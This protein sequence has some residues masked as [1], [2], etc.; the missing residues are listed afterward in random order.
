MKK[1]TL[2]SPPDIKFFKTTAQ[3]ILALS[4]GGENNGNVIFNGYDDL[5]N[6]N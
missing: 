6:M 4:I 5:W 3:N 1:K 2:Y